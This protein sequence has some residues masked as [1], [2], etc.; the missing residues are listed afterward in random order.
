[1]LL[2][3]MVSIPFRRLSKGIAPPGKLGK[4]NKK[5]NPKKEEKIIKTIR[6]EFKK[7]NIDTKKLL[8]E[9]RDLRD[10]KKIEKTAKKDLKE[11]KKYIKSLKKLYGANL[12]RVYPE[13][14]Q[15]EKLVENLYK[16]LKEIKKKGPSVH[17]ERRYHM[18]LNAIHKLWEMHKHKI[19]K[20]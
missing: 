20:T 9:F 19:S 6:K 15:L 17:L 18:I 5:L 13:I 12:N 7:I 8:K 3:F 10:I 4:I 2:K 14:I 1:M 11:I 16:T